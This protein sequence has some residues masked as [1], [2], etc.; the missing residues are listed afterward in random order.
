MASSVGELMNKKIFKSSNKKI[1]DSSKT[2]SKVKANK[3]NFDNIPLMQ[4]D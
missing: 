3:L 1:S 4:L 2:H